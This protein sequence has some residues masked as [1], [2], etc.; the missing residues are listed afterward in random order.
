M[1]PTVAALGTDCQGGAVRSQARNHQLRQRVA[2]QEQRRRGLESLRLLA[3]G[4]AHETKNPLGAIGVYT[5]LLHEGS[6]EERTRSRTALI[7]EQIDHMTE[8]LD[9]FLTFARKRLPRRES[10]DVTDL[11]RTALELLS[12]DAEAA[13]V[14]LSVQDGHDAIVR[15]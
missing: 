9:E 7:L 5:Q 15:G 6:Q 10:V 12:S 3:A 1:A 13:G 11:A 8:R 14:V 4:L 2:L